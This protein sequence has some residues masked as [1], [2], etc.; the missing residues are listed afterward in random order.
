MRVTDC[1]TLGTM[2]GSGLR[3]PE[4]QRRYRQC[5]ALGYA[6]NSISGCRVVSRRR[7]SS[8]V[9]CLGRNGPLNAAMSNNPLF[10][11][12]R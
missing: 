12:F 9:P 1:Y 3:L 6:E 8:L 2:L 4:A 5:R 7:H 11:D 10:L